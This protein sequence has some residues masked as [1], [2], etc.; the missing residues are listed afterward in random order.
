MKKSGKTIIKVVL[1]LAAAGLVLVVVGIGMGASWKDAK[2]ARWAIGP[3][4][5]DIH[6]IVDVPEVEGI[7]FLSGD[8]S[9]EEG[10]LKEVEH[11][12]AGEVSGLEFDIA[13]A[14][15]YV[16]CWD[17]DYVGIQTN[18]KLYRYEAK[19]NK[20]GIYKMES[21]GKRRNNKG[22]LAVYLPE[23]MTLDELELDMDA[24]EATLEGVTVRRMAGDVDAG[25][26]Y[27]S[28]KILSGAEIECGAGEAILNLDGRYEDY[29]YELSCGM[30]EL[31]IN[32]ES[33]GGLGVDQRIDNGA[34]GRMEL[35]CGMGRIELNIGE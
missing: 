11:L 7:P 32:G 16:G 8:D 4:I 10:I 21:E 24:G 12:S 29:N 1:G 14:R 22:I 34:A 6:E 30:G 5:P 26:L 25:A 31:E 27:F 19:L 33:Y 18:G 35:E 23:G 28:G 15:I 20:D 9:E 17:E 2:E 13:A 3:D